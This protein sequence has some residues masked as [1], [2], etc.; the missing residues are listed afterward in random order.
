[1]GLNI[2]PEYRVIANSADITATIRDRFRSLR[3]TDEAGTTSDTLEITLA[4]HLP[5]K[6]I[7]LPPTG[8]ELEVSLGYDGIVRPMGLF[9]CDEIEMSG[10]PDELVIRARAAP[11]EKSKGGKTDLQSQKSRSWKKDTTIG[12]MVKKIAS[13]HGMQASVSSG[14]ASIKLPHV[15]QKAES[16]INL[17][18]RLAKKYDAIAKPA[19][20]KLLFVK[21]GEGKAASGGAMP[22]ITIARKD[23]TRWRV[24]LASRDSA[25]TVVATY[26]DRKQA[27]NIDIAVGSGEPVRR[28]RHHYPDQKSAL[29]A[30]KAEQRKRARGEASVTVDMAGDPNLVAESMMT[31]KGF[32]DGVDGEWLVA[33]VEHYIGPQGYR[34][35]VEGEKPN[36]DDGVSKSTDS[37]EESDQSGTDEGG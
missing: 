30:A 35:S 8:A 19:G 23:A 10:P 13:E 6:P 20:G 16:D 28:L 3:I 1:M 2:A 11:Y 17:L 36:K 21:R 37:V 7:A 22:A 14:L 25:G 32:R 15:D 34:C 18:N 31:L 9:V 4:D 26:R 29:E 33:R 12:A 27:K 24:T 5:G